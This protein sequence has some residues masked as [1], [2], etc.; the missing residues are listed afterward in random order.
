[1]KYHP[2][3][4]CQHRLD[5]DVRSVQSLNVKW[6]HENG[7]AFASMSGG[8]PG[9]VYREHDQ[10]DVPLYGRPMLSAIAF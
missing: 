10:D 5:F 2:E 6:Q 9:R 8:M 4:T 3:E 7:Q 1:M